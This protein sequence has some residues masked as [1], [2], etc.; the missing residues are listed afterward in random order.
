MRRFSAN[1]V[2]PVSSPPI[3]NGIV[4][5]DDNNTIVNIYKPEKNTSE[6]H[7]TKFYNGIIIPGFVNCHCHLELSHLRNKIP[8]KTGIA[9]FVESITKNRNTNPNDIDSAIKHSLEEMVETGTVAIGD[10][11]NTPDTLIHKIQHKIYFQNFIEVFGSNPQQAQECY[12]NAQKVLGKFSEKFPNNSSI[13]PHSTYSLSNPLWNLVGTHLEQHH[14]PVSAHYAESKAEYEFLENSSGPLSKWYNKAGIYIDTNRKTSP[15]KIIT[16][17]IPANS[18][19]LLVHCTYATVN[20][21]KRLQSFFNQTTIV[22]CP[23]SNLYIENSLPDLSEFL[24]SG[25]NIAIGTD[26]LASATSLSML[27]QINIILNHFPD[28]S[29]DAVLKMATLNGAVA[30]G[31]SQNMGT[32]E[33]G[34]TPGLNLISGFDF[35]KFRPTVRSKVKKLL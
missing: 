31:F 25:L 23:E 19:V 13:T 8:Q 28:I 33:V 14:N 20:E 27:N 29:F 1:Y 7:S 5:V 9:G 21:L 11:C 12:N 6:L 16:D 35:D 15:Q 3:R 4:E 18:N 22:T 26:S 30:L 17:N 34:K 24:Q 10:I 2:F 32:I